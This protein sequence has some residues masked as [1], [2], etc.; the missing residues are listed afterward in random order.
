M[1]WGSLADF[2]FDSPVSWLWPIALLPLLSAVLCNRAA[3]LLPPTQADWRVAAIMAG[4]PGFIMVVLLTMAVGRGVLHLHLDGIGHLIEY[5]LIWVLAWPILLPAVRNARTRNR[6]LRAVVVM[7]SSPS[8]RLAAAAAAVGNE[9]RELRLTTFEC[10]LAGIW[11]PT[12]YVSA[13]AVARLSDEEL[14]AA[15][16]HERA[17]RDGADL[18]LHAVLSFLTDVVP[19]SGL[20]LQACKGARERRADADA[21]VHAGP[22]PLASAL[23]AFSR[24]H[25]AAAIGMAEV[26]PAWR[27]RAILGVEPDAGPMAAPVDSI[28]ALVASGAMACW[29]AIQVPLTFL[30]CSS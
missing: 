9:A 6:Q 18:A 11:R 5:H 30:L 8:P 14:R 29:P 28:A 24:P 23:L 13:A 27:L 26:D 19:T 21:T 1:S 3:R 16:H 25:P 12:A 7:A 2:L 15:L 4:A 22:L 20:A 10:F 17:H